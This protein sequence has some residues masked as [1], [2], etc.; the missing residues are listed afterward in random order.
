MKNCHIYVATTGDRFYPIF[1]LAVA[2]F[3]RLRAAEEFISL[4][5]ALR[6]RDVL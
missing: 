6:S 2:E 5:E 1:L 3:C 4:N